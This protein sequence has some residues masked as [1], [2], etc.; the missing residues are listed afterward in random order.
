MGN[1]QTRTTTFILVKRNNE[2]VFVEKNHVGDGE[3][4]KCEFT[5]DAN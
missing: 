4:I 3:F 2:V 1:Y 5:C